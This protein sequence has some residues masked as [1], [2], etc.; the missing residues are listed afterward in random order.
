MT[1][2]ECHKTSHCAWLQLPDRTAQDR[3]LQNE[4]ELIR[5]PVAVPKASAQCQTL[6]SNDWRY[7]GFG[8]RPRLAV[9]SPI[10]VVIL[11]A[12]AGGNRAS[13]L[14]RKRQR[15]NSNIWATHSEEI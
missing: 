2:V 7:G 5:S 15:V 6:W 13:P 11:S 1:V 14:W 8:T 12:Q 4:R 9:A 3:T 10:V